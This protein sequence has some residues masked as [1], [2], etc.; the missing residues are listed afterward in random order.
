MQFVIRN[1]NKENN[2]RLMM[3]HSNVFCGHLPVATTRHEQKN[4]TWKWATSI[5]WCFIH[6]RWELFFFCIQ[7][8]GSSANSPKLDWQLCCSV[9]SSDTSI[10]MAQCKFTIN[11]FFYFF[12]FRFH[13]I[14][15]LIWFSMKTNYRQPN[16]WFVFYTEKYRFFNQ[17]LIEQI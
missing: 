16:E 12:L 14:D 13:V 8:N 9:W 10:F 17:L 2:A 15:L 11:G 6:L 5:Y 1:V 7:I 4:M 3:I